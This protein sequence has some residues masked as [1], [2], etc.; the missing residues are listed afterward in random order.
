MLLQT[1]Q[2]CLKNQVGKLSA[3]IRC[4][5]VRQFPFVITIIANNISCH[6]KKKLALH[7]VI[8]TLIKH[9]LAIAQQG[10]LLEH[11]RAEGTVAI[12]NMQHVLPTPNHC[13]K[14]RLH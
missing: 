7:T 13:H 3:E 11:A 12:I 1:W 2:Q 6:W 4:T 9:K 8:A 10:T 5:T 14:R